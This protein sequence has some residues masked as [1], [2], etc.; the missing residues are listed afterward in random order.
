MQEADIARIRF[1][2]GFGPGTEAVTLADMS[3]SLSQPDDEAR[4]F[5]SLSFSEAL[6]LGRDF[7]AAR[8]AVREEQAGAQDLYDA[9]RAALRQEADRA[10]RH[11]FARIAHSRTPLRERLTWFWADHFTAIHRGS[12]IRAAPLSFLDETIRPHLTGHFG[13]MLKAVTKHPSMLL[14]LDQNRS[15]GPA[16]P[17]GQRQGR[18]LNENLARELLELHTMGAGS[19]YSQADVRQAAELLTGLSFRRQDGFVFRPNAAEPGPETILGQTYG[20][21]GPARL[22]DIDAFLDD[23]ALRPETARHVARK[24]AV[25]FLSDD[26]PRDVVETLHAV[27]QETEGDLGAVTAALLDHPQSASLSLQKVKW[28]MEYIA[29]GLVAFGLDG[30][31]VMDLSDREFRQMVVGPMQRMGQTFMHPD[32]PD[33]WPEA[34]SHWVAPQALAVRISWSIATARRIGRGAGD[35]RVFLDQTLGVLAGDRLRFAVSAAETREEGIA[36]AL[37]SAEFN[38]R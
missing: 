11:S 17:A 27:Y 14:Y 30:A 1:G 3:R 12:L 19:G 9:T 5:P 31:A 2:Y 6:G 24:L 26:P 18:G 22:E 10:I 25:H 20:S 8:Q 23:L 35:P 13:E 15:V 33:G 16:S 32:G 38:R 28:P 36:L 34:A 21:D 29:S 37:A 7:N 4:R